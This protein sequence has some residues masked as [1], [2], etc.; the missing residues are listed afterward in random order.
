MSVD[1]SATAPYFVTSQT[2]TAHFASEVVRGPREYPVASCPE[3]MGAKQSAVRTAA[4]LNN[5][6][7]RAS[8]GCQTCLVQEFV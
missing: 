8:S 3:A 1:I 7:T 4:D 6:V 5:M 2:F